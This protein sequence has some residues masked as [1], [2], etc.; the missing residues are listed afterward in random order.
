VAED[1]SWYEEWKEFANALNEN[2][3]PLGNCCDGLEALRLVD[4]I[5][6]SARNGR[7]VRI[8]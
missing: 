2:R 1:R 8:E 4:A 5:Y 7:T 3:E 6:Q